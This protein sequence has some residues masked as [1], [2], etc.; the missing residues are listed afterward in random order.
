[1]KNVQI[2]TDYYRFIKNLIIGLM[3]YKDLSL[4]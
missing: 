4:K 1:M 3:I 2:F